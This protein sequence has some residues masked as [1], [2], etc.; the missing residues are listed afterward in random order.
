MLSEPK[1]I[2][3]GVP[4]GSI[5]GPILFS[6]YIN[7]IT[8]SLD[9]S[10]VLLYADDA[11]IHHTSDD[12]QELKLVLQGDLTNLLAWSMAN[13]LSIH[14][15]KTEVV[16]FGT[17][18]KTSKV[19]KFELFLGER[20]VKQLDHYKY[21]GIILDADLKILLWMQQIRCINQ[22]SCQYWIIVMSHGIALVRINV[23]NWR[24][25]KIEQ[26]I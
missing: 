10:Q 6:L 13:R 8:A 19:D 3:S 4:Q 9:K 25:Y 12:I 16:L 15:V 5:L 11:V 1:E 23:R 21:L 14:P 17:H 20:L 26:L 24:G 22:Q 7:D 18:Q 2:R